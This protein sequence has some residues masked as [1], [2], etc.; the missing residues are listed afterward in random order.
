MASELAPSKWQTRYWRPLNIKIQSQT[1]EKE[2]SA[3]LDRLAKR[4]HFE[5]P[6]FPLPPGFETAHV[7]EIIEVLPQFRARFDSFC[8]A[9]N[10]QGTLSFLAIEDGKASG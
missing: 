7:S 6:I 4:A 8:Y 3:R 5:R 1:A 9:S 10:L 2:E